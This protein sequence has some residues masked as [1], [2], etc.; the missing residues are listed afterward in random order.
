MPFNY[1]TATH[2]ANLQ[3]DL[4]ARA[5]Y[6]INALREAGVPAYIS[7]SIRTPDFQASLVRGGKSQRLKSLHLE[8][9]AFDIDILGYGRDKLPKWWWQAVGEFAE[10][11]GMRWG[12]R[13]TSL[14]DAGHFEL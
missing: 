6:F 8:G 1:R 4:G 5:F 13:W 14:Y 3:P 12:G 9:R 11:L 2:I 10:S 7:S